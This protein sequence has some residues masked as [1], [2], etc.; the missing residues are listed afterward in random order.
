MRNIFI[1]KFSKLAKDVRTCREVN[2]PRAC[3]TEW[4]KSERVHQTL[5]I[6]AYIW[7]LE[8]WYWCSYLQGKNRDRD[9]ENRPV[10]TAGEGDG[11]TNWESS[12]HL[13]TLPCAKQIAGSSRI[14]Q[15]A[16]PSALWSSTG[17]RWGVRWGVGWGGLGREE[18]YVYYTWFTLSYSRSQHNIVKQLSSN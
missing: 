11:G 9:I 16:Q 12:V 3:Y 13:Y 2:E 14:T 4:G 1:H 7:D 15:G 5:Y 10:N 8:K 6:N 18:I 17:V